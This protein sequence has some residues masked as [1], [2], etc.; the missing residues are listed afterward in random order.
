M[1]T[2]SIPAL[3]T[4]KHCFNITALTDLELEDDENFTIAIRKISLPDLT[5]PLIDDVQFNETIHIINVPPS[6]RTCYYN[7]TSE[8]ISTF[9]NSVTYTYGQTCERALFSAMTRVGNVGV[10]IDSFKGTFKTTRIGIRLGLNE[11][12]VVSAYNRD[13]IRKSPL[14]LISF[15]N[16]TTEL[17]ISVSSLGL[18]VEITA[19]G[20]L[21]IVRTNSGLQNHRGLC[22]N[23]DGQFTT[24]N[25]TIVD[26]RN[27]E[28]LNRMIRQLLIP[29]SEAFIIMVARRECGKFI[30]CIITKRMCGKGTN[31]WLNLC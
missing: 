19:N 3:S 30:P 24:R 8:E 15:T 21:V 11:S 4:D 29:P 27:M 12:I 23:E 18:R 22:G 16:T 28:N 13:V 17:T 20:V 26:I 2:V 7:A 31:V 5:P 9:K 14:N 10:F 6:L 1:K 25:G